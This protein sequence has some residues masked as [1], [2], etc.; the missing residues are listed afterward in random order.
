MASDTTREEPYVKPASILTWI[1]RIAA[2]ILLVMGAFIWT[3]NYDSLVTIHILVGVVFTIALLVLTFQAFRGGVARG[4]VLLALVVDLALPV[5]GLTQGMIFP[6]SLAMVGGIVHL[7]L[8][9][10]AWVLAEMLTLR[11]G[12]KVR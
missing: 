2:A 5:L 7:A 1:I 3:G 11:L 10:G 4:L 9:V 12:K 8:G 6:E